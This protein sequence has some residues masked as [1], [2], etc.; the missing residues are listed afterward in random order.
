MQVLY[1]KE[2]VNTIEGLGEVNKSKDNSMRIGLVKFVV[3]EMEE[4]NEIVGD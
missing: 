2:V 1:D 3:D 4:A